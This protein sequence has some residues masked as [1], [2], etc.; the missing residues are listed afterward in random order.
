MIT[1]VA[2]G[3][4]VVLY[5]PELINLYE[6]SIGPETRIGNW[7]ALQDFEPLLHLRRRHD[8]GRRVSGSWRHVHQ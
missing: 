8:R 6:F 7:R 4:D 2:L 3:K 1:D 5:H